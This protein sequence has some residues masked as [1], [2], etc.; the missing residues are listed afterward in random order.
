MLAILYDLLQKSYGRKK[1]LVIWE[2]DRLPFPFKERETTAKN[3]DFE[4]EKWFDKFNGLPEET[5]RRLREHTPQKQI[6]MS[7]ALKN[8][9]G[10]VVE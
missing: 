4:Y 1:D 2:L 5:K 9:N 3:P 6:V 8:W 10:M 7:E